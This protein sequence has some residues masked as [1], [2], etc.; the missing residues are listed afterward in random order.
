MLRTSSTLV[1][2]LVFF[3][4]VAPLRAQRGDDPSLDRFDRGLKAMQAKNYAEGCRLLQASLRMKRRPGTLF[5]LAECLAGWGRIAKAVQRY[6]EY[7]SWYQ[8]MPPTVQQD[9]GERPGLSK[10]QIDLLKP[11]IPLLT[12]RLAPGTPSGSIVWLD[13]D[14]VIR[15]LLNYPLPIDPGEH[16]VTAQAPGGPIAEEKV[17]LGRSESKTITIK[18]PELPPP[19]PPP[20]VSVGWNGRRIAAVGLM[21]VGGAGILAGSIAGGIVLYQYQVIKGN[22]GKAIGENNPKVC[23]DTGMKMVDSIDGPLGNIAVPV[24]F[25]VGVPGFVTGL[26][27]Y[28]TEPTPAPK[29]TRSS[30]HIGFT[31]VGPSGL[32]LGATGRF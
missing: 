12:I 7:L 27:L 10:K 9:Q 4:G 18:V 5:T 1:F 15:L 23:N 14:I 22:C 31:K 13:G 29:S 25:G 3:A 16:L 19:P 26:V 28:R 32:M 20:D 11:Q 24:L 21:G 17:V 6:E 2:L 8:E 30:L